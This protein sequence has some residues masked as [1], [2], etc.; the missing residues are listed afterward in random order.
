MGSA[1][2]TYLEANPLRGLG[3]LRV[4]EH[5]A[6]LLEPDEETRLLATASTEDR[7][8]IICAV[9]T[10]L[11]LS[12]VAALRREHDH[13]SYLSVLNPKVAGYKVPV[14][15]RLRAA[16]DALPSAGPHY[17][18]SVQRRTANGRRKAMRL[19][20]ERL[21]RRAG[22][23]TGRAAGGLTFHCLRHTGA[24]RMLARGVDIETVRELG[25]WQNLNA[26]KRYLHPT[27]AHKQA[28]VEVIGSG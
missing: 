1:V 4:P 26:L 20:F 8:I 18:P 11:R 10:L 14:S 12:N 9:D 23:P 24:S 13:R 2:P 25:G 6:R 22:L 7:A 28:A 19:L 16:L 17:F 3:L 27:A 21:C 5:E 15:T